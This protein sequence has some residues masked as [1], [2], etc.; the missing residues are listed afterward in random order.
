MS[1]L[2]SDISLVIRDVDW[3]FKK[4][5]AE[6]SDYYTAKSENINPSL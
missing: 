3:K 2:H 1:D 6:E 5:W 4:Y